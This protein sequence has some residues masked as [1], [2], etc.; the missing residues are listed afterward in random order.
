[1]IPSTVARTPAPAA[2][3]A[4]LR[5]WGGTHSWRPAR[6]LAPRDEGELGAVV[7]RASADGMRVRAMGAGISR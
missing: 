6:R 2:S 5:T 7:A 3:D 1:M 4:P